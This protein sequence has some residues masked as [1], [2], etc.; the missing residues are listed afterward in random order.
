MPAEFSGMARLLIV[1]GLLIAGL[2]VLLSV[3]GRLP[4]LGRLPGDM[5]IRRDGVFLYIP[6]TSGLLLSLI[7]TVVMRLFSR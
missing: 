4:W 7:V 1:M 6:L 5:L 3:A 2:G